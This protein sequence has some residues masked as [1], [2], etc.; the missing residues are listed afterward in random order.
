M[1]LDKID[2][3][4]ANKPL[5]LSRTQ[6]LSKSVGLEAEIRDLQ[7]RR[8]EITG[9]VESLNKKVNLGEL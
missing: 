8:A 9:K 7:K 3:E 5:C 2:T 6:T 1:K 4:I